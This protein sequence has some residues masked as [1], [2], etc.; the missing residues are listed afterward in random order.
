MSAARTVIAVGAIGGVLGGLALLLNTPK[1]QPLPSSSWQTYAGSYTQADVEAGARMIASENPR[2]SRRLHIEQVY[3]QLRARKRGESLFDRITADSGWGEQG[4][5]RP[6]GRK[7]PVSTDKPADDE[8][9]EL[10]R[11]ILDGLHPS[12][13]RGAR[14]FFEPSQSDLAFAIGERA[15]GKIARGETL[16][17]QERRL[18]KYHKNADAV[19]REWLGDGS[20]YLQTIDGVEFYT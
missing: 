12:E 15:R 11:A 4:E 9:R 5:A 1:Q 16:S 18:L 17:K 6:P 10:V 2:A 7:R 14:K 13:L 20:R 19:R 8:G 3:T